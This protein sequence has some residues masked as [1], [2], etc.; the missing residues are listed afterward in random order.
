[1]E[2]LLRKPPDIDFNGLDNFLIDEGW[3]CR[4]PASGSSHYTYWK[5]GIPD[6]LTIKKDG[7]RV[8]RTYI[9]KVISALGLESN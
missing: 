5:E 8:S 3:H 7:T 6:I 2:R 1:M 9:V 4:Q